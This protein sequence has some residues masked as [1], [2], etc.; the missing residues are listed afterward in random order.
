MPNRA[1]ALV[2]FGATGDLS[3]RKLFP[4]LYALEKHGK[5]DIPVVGVA[6]SGWDDAGFRDHARTSIEKAVDKPDLAIID[7]LCA[8]LVLVDGDYASIDTFQRLAR[9]LTD[10]KATTPC[11]TWHPARPLP[12]IVRRWQPSGSTGGRLVVEKPFVAICNRPSN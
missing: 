4:S 12:T 2:L 10:V 1:D 7:A 9:T 5:L 11:S 3:K 8:R 6:R